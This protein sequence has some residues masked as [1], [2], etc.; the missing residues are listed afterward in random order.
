MAAQK[1]AFEPAQPLSDLAAVV[2]DS[3]PPGAWLTG[4]SIERGKPLQMRGAARTA[5]DVARF[6]DTLGATS[7]F[8][9]VKLVFA[10][11]A[12][13]DETPVVQ[14]SVTA[15]GVGNLPMPAPV[16]QARRG[17]RTPKSSRDSR[18]GGER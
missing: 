2:D 15:V 3:L 16:K 4:L 13:I 8:R 5:D 14:F 18:M 7:R 12:R 6:M 10:N 17:A 9:D 11:S 1:R